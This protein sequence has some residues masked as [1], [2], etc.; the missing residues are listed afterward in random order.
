MA[1]NARVYSDFGYM[2]VITKGNSN[3][4]LFEEEKDYSFYLRLLEKYS[5]EMEIK[6][7]A[8][9][10]MDN[11]VHLLLYD[12]EHQIPFLMKKIGVAYS[13][14]FNKK[15]ERTG[16]LFQG[17]YH[18]VCVENE[19]ALR[20]VFRYIMQNPKK[21]G[22]CSVEDYLWS[23]Y[24]KYGD[25][26]SFVDTSIL[27][28]LIGDWDAYRYIVGTDVNDYWPEHELKKRDDEWANMILKRVL[29]VSNG[30]ILQQYDK[31]SRDKAIRTL[32]QK[33]LSIRQI[34]RITG[35]NRGVVQRA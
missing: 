19:L 1:R 2:H 9:C 7:V 25:P 22:I 17:R 33:G 3:Q 35:I 23:S 29:H 28:D 6:V 16:H 5:T 10:L 27:V 4:I 11:H 18:S 13:G 30:M 24:S 21:A 34:E 32:K 8:Y 12:P 15:Y 31:A 26:T 14:Y 20:T